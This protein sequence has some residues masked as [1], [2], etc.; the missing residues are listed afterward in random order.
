MTRALRAL[1]PDPRALLGFFLSRLEAAGESKRWPPW[2]GW[3]TT[4]S[5]LS[6]HSTD[7]LPNRMI[8]LDLLPYADDFI[9]YLKNMIR[10]L[11]DTQVIWLG[12]ETTAVTARL[13]FTPVF[14]IFWAK[15]FVWKFKSNIGH[16]KDQVSSPFLITFIRLNLHLI[17]TR[18]MS[19]D[20][21]DE[22]TEEEGSASSAKMPKI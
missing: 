4:P 10:S 22:S 8:S 12:P 17:C 21:M 19:K 16:S 13:R 1:P 6:S 14:E 2:P 15:Q 5:R 11:S 3:S 9:R 7:S 20:H 18:D